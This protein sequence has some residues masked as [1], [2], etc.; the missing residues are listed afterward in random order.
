MAPKTASRVPMHPAHRLRGAVRKVVS[1]AAEGWL[2]SP[3][4]HVLRSASVGKTKEALRAGRHA[5]AKGDPDDVCASV[6]EVMVDLKR[7]D[8][9]Q[10]SKWVSKRRLFAEV[11]VLKQCN[12][13]NQH[14]WAS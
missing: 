11:S 14:A 10:T 3:A 6:D 1:E 7:R 12:T 8:H 9:R 13:R 2:K 5:R 4:F